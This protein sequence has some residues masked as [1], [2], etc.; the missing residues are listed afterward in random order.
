MKIE[1]RRR[2]LVEMASSAA[3]VSALGTDTFAAGAGQTAVRGDAASAT[4][5]AQQWKN[6]LIKFSVIGINHGHIYAQVNAV[7]RGGGEL[8]SV[9]AKE[10]D[11]LAAFQKDFPW[12][13]AARSEDEI[14]QDA[15]IKLVVTSGIPNERAPL[16]IRCMKAGKDFMTDKPGMTTLEQL[17]EVRKVQAETKRIYSIA[18][19]ERHENGATIRAGELVK[20]GAIG[21]VLQTVGLGPHRMNPKTRPEWFFDRAKYGGI[22]TDIASHQADQFL[23]FTNSTKASVVASQVGNL[24]NPQWPGLDDFG[25]MVAARQRRHGLRARRLVHAGRA[26]LVGDG[27]LTVLGTDGFI[28]LRKN[29]DIG[30]RPGG[31]HLFLVDQKETKYIDCK[32]VELPYGK[33]L[34][35]DIAEPHRDGHAAG[36]LLPRDGARARGAGQGAEGHGQSVVWDA[37][38]KGSGVISRGTDSGNSSRTPISRQKNSRKSSREGA[39]ISA[40]PTRMPSSAATADPA[41][42][43]ASTLATSPVSSTKPLPPMAIARCTRNSDTSAD[44]AAASATSMMLDAENVSM[45]PSARARSGTRS[46]DSPMAGKTSGWTCVMTRFSMSDPRQCAAPASTEADTAATSPPTTTRYL[47]EQMVRASSSVTSAAFS[48]ASCAR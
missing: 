26:G 45:T 23:F 31:S 27:R 42:T 41:A 40:L 36:A 10:P 15:S 37:K 38:G 16:G 24:N 47:P 39:G 12:V 2:F 5:A 29:I 13:K 43:A 4:G 22:L 9:Y 3:V 19:S 25:D 6:P 44:F 34:V 1:D 11:L 28:E 18:Y 35:Q 46:T 20:A 33:N 7:I 30:G 17:A 21:R 14:L 8:I 48:I 32:D